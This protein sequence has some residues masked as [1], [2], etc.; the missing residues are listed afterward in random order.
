VHLFFM[1]SVAHCAKERDSLLNIN[2]PCARSVL[3]FHGKRAQSRPIIVKVDG[4][5]RQWAVPH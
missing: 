5:K 3:G 4:L 1:A 2:E